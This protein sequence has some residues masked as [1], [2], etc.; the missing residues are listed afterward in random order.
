MD[1]AL[2]QTSNE[3]VSIAQVCFVVKEFLGM[4]ENNDSELLIRDLINLLP[5]ICNK[6]QDIAIEV[7]ENEIDDC[8]MREALVLLLQ[9]INQIFS[10][11]ELY[12][13]AKYE[14]LLKGKLVLIFIYE[15]HKEKEKK[16]NGD[17]ENKNLISEGLSTI[18]SKTRGMNLTQV[19]MKDLVAEAYR[20]FEQMHDIAEGRSIILACSIVNIC[21]TVMKHAKVFEN[22][23][24][25][26]HGNIYL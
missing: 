2:T 21:G 9:L 18:A 6:L 25:E 3:A 12:N 26:A 10:W 17:F 20:F 14:G 11:K 5:E 23:N 4:L 8:Q 7:K 15:N 1:M 22:E 16:A 19:S 13:S 24:K